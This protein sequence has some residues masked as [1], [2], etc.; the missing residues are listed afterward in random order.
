MTLSEAMDILRDGHFGEKSS[1]YP[2][3]VYKKAFR[4]VTDTIIDLTVLQERYYE[5]LHE[6]TEEEH[7]E[8][9]KHIPRT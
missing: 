3:S 1:K 6:F 2:A 8:L 7:R 9:V 5:R 4:K